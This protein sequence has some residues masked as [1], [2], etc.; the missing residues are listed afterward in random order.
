[1]S[2]SLSYEGVS[3]NQQDEVDKNYE[4]FLAL[5]PDLME[6]D[7]NRFALMHG[8]KVIACFDTLRD[9]NEAG[10]RLLRNKLFSIQEITTTDVDL[11]YFSHVEDLGRV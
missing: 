10:R 6:T 2:S 4:A 3:R 8:R 9:A 7:A 11:G 1:M 5:L